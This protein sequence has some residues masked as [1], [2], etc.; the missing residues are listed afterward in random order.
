MGCDGIVR[1]GRW[2]F[3]GLR[4]IVLLMLMFGLDDVVLDFLFFYGCGD[5]CFCVVVRYV[6]V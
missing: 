3:V 5:F 6:D 4:D 1:V 2:V